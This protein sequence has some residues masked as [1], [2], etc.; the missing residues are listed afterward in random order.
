MRR[1]WLTPVSM[2]VRCSI[3]ALDAALH[4]DEGVAGLA[5][6]A[7][8][9]RPELDASRPLPKASAASASRRIGRIWLRRNRIATP[10][11]TSDVPTIQSDEDVRVRRVGL[12]AVG[13][14][15]HDA[16]VELDADLDELERPTVSI[17][18]GRPICVADLLARAPRRGSRRTASAPAAAGGSRG[19][20]S[21]SRPSRSLAI[22]RAARRPRPADRSRRCRSAPRC[23]RV[24]AAD[25]RRVTSCQWRSMK[26]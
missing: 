9:A 2:A 12:R 22:T 8:A 14:D 1:S 24:T 15:A 3:G 4:L 18:N 7:R 19:R 6:L 20:R 23:R 5:H 16:V 26:T 17:Q 10:S 21:T 13:D 25:R 11:S